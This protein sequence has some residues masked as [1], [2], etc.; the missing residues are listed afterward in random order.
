MKRRQQDATLMKPA[1]W[2]TLALLATSSVTAFTVE[3]EPPTERIPPGLGGVDL[4]VTITITC[5]EVWERSPPPA[6][7]TVEVRA[8]PES[9]DEEIIVAGPDSI[10][11]PTKECTT[12]NDP[13]IQHTARFTASATRGATAFQPTLITFNMELQGGEIGE[14]LNA[15]GTQSVEVEYYSAMA[16]NLINSIVRASSGETVTFELVLTNFGNAATT[17]QFT[18]QEPVATGLQVVLPEPIQIAMSTNE[19]PSVATAIITVKL[20]EGELGW[21]NELFAIEV[22]VAT[23]ATEDETAKGTDLSASLLIR[24]RGVQSTPAPTAIMVP[25][26][27]AAVALVSRRRP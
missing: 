19:S 26:A 14:P 8:Q 16:L 9:S 10:L 27:L 5:S 20:P 15:T 13:D 12:P 6:N 3:V 1:A 2:L 18:L 17:A 4:P 24:N 22:A 23:W 25:L 11:I 21:N 7:Q